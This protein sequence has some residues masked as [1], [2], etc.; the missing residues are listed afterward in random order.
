[1]SWE[2]GGGNGR[3][4]TAR[5]LPAL[6]QIPWIVALQSFARPACENSIPLHNLRDAHL[7]RELPGISPEAGRGHSFATSKKSLVI[8]S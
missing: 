2:N 5:P 6:Y 4:V 8:S 1:M 3:R 7:W